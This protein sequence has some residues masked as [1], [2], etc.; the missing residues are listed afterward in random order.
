MAVDTKKKRLSMIGFGDG[1]ILHTLPEPD[2]T[3]DPGDR[4]HLLGLFSGFGIT[5]FRKMIDVH[6]RTR[7]IEPRG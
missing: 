6:T 1:V 7:I 4:L 5:E 3:I 2:G